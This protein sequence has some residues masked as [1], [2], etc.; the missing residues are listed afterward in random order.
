MKGWKN[1]QTAKNAASVISKISVVLCSL[2]W[3]NNFVGL[4]DTRKENQTC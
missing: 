4:A 1:A 2:L 3:S